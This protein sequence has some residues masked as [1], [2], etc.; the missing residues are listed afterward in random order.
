M[1]T[2][3]KFLMMKLRKFFKIHWFC[4]IYFFIALLSGYIKYFLISLSIVIIHELSHLWMAS[5]YK[6]KVE[7]MVIYPFGA[8]LQM[9]YYGQYA[10]LKEVLVAMSGPLSHIFI[11]FFLVTFKSKLGY[12][13][14]YYACDFN[15]KM[16]LF[17]LLPIYP[18][19]GYRIFLGILSFLFPYRLTLTIMAVLSMVVYLGVV[20]HYLMINTYFLFGYLAYLQVH[21]YMQRDL[22]YRLFLFYRNRF[23]IYKKIKFNPGYS[24]YRPYVNL[25]NKK[26]KK[27]GKK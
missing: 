17:N 24:Y 2:E 16:A 20:Y 10:V 12:L 19:D 7:R 27:V 23:V 11:Y 3:K 15:L 21:L 8:Y 14:Y 5:F 22:V 26:V 18:L 13:N 6:F 25:Y 1:I 4:W 9:P